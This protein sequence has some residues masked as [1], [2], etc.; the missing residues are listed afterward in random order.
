MG[1]SGKARICILGTARSGK[2]HSALTLASGL[3]KKIALVSHERDN[4]HADKFELDFIKL[5]D[6]SKCDS[7]IK[8]MEE[9][10]FRGN[11]V[12]IIDTLIDYRWRSQREFRIQFDEAVLNSKCHIIITIQVIGEP[13]EEGVV[14]YKKMIRHDL[15]IVEYMLCIFLASKDK[16]FTLIPIKD[17][18]GMFSGKTFAPTK[19]MGDK[20]Y[21]WVEN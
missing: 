3:G 14:S 4:F 2:T 13:L 18:T 12:I 20:I 7:Y 1:N 10:E 15:T 21:D 9:A 8:A 5:G 16:E 11:D 17:R 19:E 6:P